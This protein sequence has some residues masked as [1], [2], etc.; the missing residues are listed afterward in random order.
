MKS[1]KR[2]D[3]QKARKVT[4]SAT[5]GRRPVIV[6]GKYVHNTTVLALAPVYE[7]YNQ[8]VD[9]VLNKRQEL[10]V[11]LQLHK[12]GSIALVEMLP[13]HLRY[14]VDEN[15]IDSDVYPFSSFECTC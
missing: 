1:Y 7:Y 15:E 2:G 10:L 5:G 14:H 4:E 11:Y 6:T 13:K 9:S 12:P 8:N 3:V